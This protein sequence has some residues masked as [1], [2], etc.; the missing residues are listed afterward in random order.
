MPPTPECSVPKKD[1]PRRPGFLTVLSFPIQA[2]E[3]RNWGLGPGEDL[4]SLVSKEGAL[5]HPKAAHALA[6][7]HTSARTTSLAHNTERLTSTVRW[8][9][10]WW[11]LTAVLC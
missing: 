4:G 9:Q 7:A 3:L 11:H 10:P 5:T 6:G 8:L 1:A 2:L